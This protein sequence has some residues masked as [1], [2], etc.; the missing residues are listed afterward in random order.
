MLMEL[1]TRR[2]KGAERALARR[3]SAQSS[4]EVGQTLRGKGLRAR[5]ACLLLC[6]PF[7]AKLRH[8][9]VAATLILSLDAQTRSRSTRTRTHPRRRTSSSTSTGPSGCC[10]TTMRR[11]RVW[12]AVSQKGDM[13]TQTLLNLLP[14]RAHLTDVSTSV[15]LQRTRRSCR[16][17]IA[18]STKSSCSSPTRRPGDL[19]L[20][21]S[22]ALRLSTSLSISASLS[23]SERAHAAHAPCYI[24]QHHTSSSVTGNSN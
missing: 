5:R 6:A 19:S 24:I 18:P 4:V 16:S 11:S 21:L 22:S 3:E 15:P 10:S 7:A 20:S 1:T 14:S 8:L 12:G 13:P 9:F 2:A 17:S 23:L